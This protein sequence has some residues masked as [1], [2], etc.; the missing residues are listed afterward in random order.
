[1]VAGDQMRVIAEVCDYPA[2]IAALRGRVAEHQICLSRLDELTGMSDRYSSK[3]L[4]PG[5]YGQ[6]TLGLHSLGPVLQALGVKLILA[7]DPET[8]ARM[9]PR[10]PRANTSQQ[11]VKAGA[12]RKPVDRSFFKEIGRLGGLKRAEVIA[13]QKRRRQQLR[14]A[15]QRHRARLKAGSS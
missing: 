13:Y 12:T 6:R 11:R 1:M 15:Q 14:E 7:D 9:E 4:T 5:G 10:W 8:R 3:V 2:L